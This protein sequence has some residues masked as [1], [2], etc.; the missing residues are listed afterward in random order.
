MEGLLWNRKRVLRVYII[1]NLKMR[2][3]GNS[4][5]IDHLIPIQIS[6]DILMKC[7]DEMSFYSIFYL[8]AL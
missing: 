8:K 1:L 6:K 4:S 2:R 3:S 7:L 5:D